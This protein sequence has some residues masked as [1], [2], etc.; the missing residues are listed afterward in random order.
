M[1]KVRLI[2]QDFTNL[3]RQRKLDAMSCSSRP[4]TYKEFVVTT[5]RTF[6]DALSTL[7]IWFFDKSRMKPGC[8]DALK[9]Y[10]IKL[11]AEVFRSKT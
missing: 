6:N 5:I 7:E 4:A 11:R 1:K 10:Q 8:C 2:A 3:I 9:I